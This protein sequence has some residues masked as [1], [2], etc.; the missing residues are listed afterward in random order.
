[1]C[2]FPVIKKCFIVYFSPFTVFTESPYQCVSVINYLSCKY[3][4]ELRTE[5]T[6][7]DLT[8]F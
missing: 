6:S 5:L 1:M 4:H 2:N 7:L 3:S 8:C